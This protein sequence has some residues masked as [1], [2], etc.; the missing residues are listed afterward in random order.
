[1]SEEE[2]GRASL[3]LKRG[4]YQILVDFTQP[5]PDFARHE[6]VCPQRT[7]FEVKYCGPDSDG[8]L[9]A[10][11]LRRLFRD[12]K[13]DTLASGLYSLA[14]TP[15]KQVLDLQFTGTLRDIRR[16][17][18]RAFKAALF[19]HRFGLSATPVAHYGQSELGYMLAHADEFAGRS[20]FRNPIPFSQHAANFDF[21]LLPLQDN[22]HP[23]TPIQDQRVQPSAKRM[24]ALFDWWERIFDYTRMRR[25]A[26]S[27]LEP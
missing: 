21:N 23:P 8:R 10:L 18:Q 15:A 2:I 27:P 17:Y 26:S 5:E 6:G 19:A 16:T 20:Y 24:Q 11:P 4:A 12:T 14:A 13:D 1:P 3:P 7:G 9:V 25:E 22:Y